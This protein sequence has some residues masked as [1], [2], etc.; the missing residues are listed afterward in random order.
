MM[1]NPRI[2]D[3]C[4]IHYREAVAAV[5][6][7]HGKLGTIRIVARPSGS[8]AETIRWVEAD[9]FERRKVVKRGP[10]N[11]LVELDEGGEVVVPC[12]NLYAHEED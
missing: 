8:V 9:V 1:S 5:M 7:H 6:P 10:R 2:G 3:R 12:G 4:R 11:H